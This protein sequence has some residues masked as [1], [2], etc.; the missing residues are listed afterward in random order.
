MS[1]QA[2]LPAQWHAGGS[3]RP[4]GA[5]CNTSVTGCS[6]DPQSHRIPKTLGLLMTSARAIQLQICFLAALLAVV[7][8]GC[9]GA[10][11][12]YVSHLERGKQYLE[13]GNLDKAGIEFRNAL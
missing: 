1:L 9:G 10:R 8:S 7:L 5:P 3:A 12:R 6:Y 11:A 4:R 2:T 13:Q